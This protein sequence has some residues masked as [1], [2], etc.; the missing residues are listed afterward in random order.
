MR[1]PGDDSDEIA[2]EDYPSNSPGDPGV[3]QDYDPEEIPF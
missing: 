1:E 3:A 2:A